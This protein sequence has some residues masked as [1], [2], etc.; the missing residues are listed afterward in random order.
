[1][2]RS[3][4]KP[5]PVFL[6]A[7]WFGLAAGLVEGFTYLLFEYAGLLSCETDLHAVNAN[8]LWVSPAM[9]LFIFLAVACL[10]KPLIR[11]LG[12]HALGVVVTAFSVLGFYIF[13]AV[14]GRLSE[15]SASVLGLGLGTVANRWVTRDPASRLQLVKKTFGPLA[16]TAVVVLVA[17]IGGGPVLETIELARLPAPPRNAPNVLLIVLDT[18]RSDRLGC[19]GSPL[20][21]TPFLDQ[22]SREAV[23]FEKA[24]ANAPWTLPS[25]VSFF[26]GYLPSAHRAIR[27]R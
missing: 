11:P 10:L 27:G 17:V 2:N 23:L 26:T 5:V 4:S 14:S 21:T 6:L 8:I 16:A 15:I 19:Y 7:V 12:R 22:Y 18:L 13:L 9:D 24:F 25:H 3:D 20:P 1:M